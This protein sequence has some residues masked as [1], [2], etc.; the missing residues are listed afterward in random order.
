[1]TEDTSKNPV[2]VRRAADIMQAPFPV[3]R[4]ALELKEI[5]RLEGVAYFDRLTR[6][7]NADG[8]I[9][10][11]D[12]LIEALWAIKE[13]LEKDVASQENEYTQPPNVLVFSV[14]LVGLKRA[15]DAKG[16]AAGNAKIKAVGEALQK[17]FQR[18]LDLYGRVSGDE[19]FVFAFN[20]P[21]NG[22]EP[23]YGKLMENLA[24]D[25]ELYVVAQHVD[26]GRETKMELLFNLA[27]S[28]LDEVIKGLDKDD[29]D[30]T[31]RLKS[32]GFRQLD[33]TIL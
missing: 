18:S 9:K 8:L 14:D 19:F 22:I 7:P 21:E 5:D 29:F 25:V 15:N 31:G 27:E 10:K 24:E 13:E 17:T 30:E 4:F 6:I 33:K 3:E 12:E 16:R 20:T 26:I 28:N 1:M 11:G 32:G 23:L 2:Y